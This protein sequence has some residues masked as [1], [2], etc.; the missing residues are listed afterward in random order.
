MWT[1]HGH[2]S[3]ATI[4]G[5][6]YHIKQTVSQGRP[7]WHGMYLCTCAPCNWSSFLNVSLFASLLFCFCFFSYLIEGE[8]LS[9]I[10]KLVSAIHQHESTIGIHIPP[11]SWTSLSSPTPSQQSNGFELLE[12]YSKFPRL[13]N[14]IYDSACF[15]A[16]LSICPTL[17]FPSCGYTF[18][19]YVCVFIAALQKGLSVPSS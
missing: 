4:W 6:E 8:L 16:P 13:S 12:S 1:L 17:F 9:N 18:V 7:E 19:L 11:P 5:S 3:D 14:F 15:H 10:A 2:P